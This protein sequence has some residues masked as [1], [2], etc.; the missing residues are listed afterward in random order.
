[1]DEGRALLVTNA[2]KQRVGS[3]DASTSCTRTHALGFLQA[4]FCVF[5]LEIDRNSVSAA[6]WIDRCS[7]ADIFTVALTS[8]QVHEHFAA[9]PATMIAM[10]TICISKKILFRDIVSCVKQAYRQIAKMFFA[11]PVACVFAAMVTTGVPA[12]HRIT[13]YGIAMLLAG[14]LVCRIIDGVIGRISFLR[15]SKTVI[16]NDPPRESNSRQHV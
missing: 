6:R 2:G 11:M 8:L 4:L 1:M 3:I 7:S 15:E 9:F 12:P 14:L 13:L 10:L 16:A 5:A